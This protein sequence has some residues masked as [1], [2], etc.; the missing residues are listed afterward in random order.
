MLCSFSTFC[1][2]AAK[3]VQLPRTLSLKRFFAV[4]FS[5]TLLLTGFSGLG[6]QVAQARPDAPSYAKHGPFAVG[7]MDITIQSA[8]RPLTATVWYPA[9][10]PTSAEEKNTYHYGAYPVEGHALLNAAPDGSKGPYPLIVFSHGNGGLRLQSLFYT[11]HLASYGFVVISADHP[12]SDLSLAALLGA[13]KPQSQADFDT[14]Y[15]QRP[16]DMLREIAQAEQLN[17]TGGALAGIIDTNTIA[18]SGHS[19]GGYTAM[20][21]GG[22]RLNLDALNQWCGSNPD[23][24]LDPK[25]VCFMKDSGFP[26]AKARGL[27]AAPT[28]VWPATTDPRIKA[29]VAMAPWNAEIFGKDGLAA[30]TI[31]TL[32]MVGTKDTTTIPERDAFVFYNGIGS[33]NKTLVTFDNAN[34]VVFVDACPAALAKTSFFSSCSDQVW[35]MDRIHDLINQIATPY[36]LSTLKHDPSAAAAL[37]SSA[38]NYVG[39]N[40]K[41]Q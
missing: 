29:I 36:L 9:L 1:G 14:N 30:V 32:I 39:V 40:Y 7:T 2:K 27:T 11:E 13:A 15:A 41:T 10:N 23:P 22:A 8:T 21:T 12:G 37:A 18:V 25:T 35:D 16:L 3:S 28:G 20:A 24:A 34:H 19:F 33:A 17:A 5:L 6:S 31:P 4:L 38:V 26:I